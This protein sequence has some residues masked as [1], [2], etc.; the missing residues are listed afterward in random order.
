MHIKINLQPISPCFTK[1]GKR[2]ESCDSFSPTR[3]FWMLMLSVRFEKPSFDQA[4]D[5]YPGTGYR[6][7][8]IF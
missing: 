4:A 7:T 5:G 1:E 3:F 2:Q 8:Q 6:R